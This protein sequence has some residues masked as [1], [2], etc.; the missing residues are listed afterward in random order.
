MSWSDNAGNSTTRPVVV[1]FTPSYF[2]DA[3]ALLAKLDPPLAPELYHCQKVADVGDLYVVVMD[4]V[5]EDEGLDNT[6]ISSAAAQQVDK[7]I[8]H[9]H[10]NDFQRY[11]VI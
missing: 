8:N 11:L 2:K 9:L 1:K 5:A 3:H 10:G 7:A 4:Y 6:V